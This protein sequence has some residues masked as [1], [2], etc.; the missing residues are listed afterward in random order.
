MMQVDF[1]KMV[2][3]HIVWKNRLTDLLTRELNVPLDLAKIKEDKL[4]YL[5]MF[6]Y[7]DEQQ[8]VVLPAFEEVRVLYANLYS[9]FSEI[10]RLYQAGQHE[11]ATQLMHSRFELVSKKLN[12]KIILLAKQYNAAVSASNHTNS[13][14]N[15]VKGLHT[16]HFGVMR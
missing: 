2:N 11:K 6:T 15:T 9:I 4:C 3:T 10:L 1:L 8:L 5:S 12:S 14:L 16:P 13:Y 7:S